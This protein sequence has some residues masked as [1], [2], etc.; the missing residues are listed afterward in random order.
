[1]GTTLSHQEVKDMALTV[2]TTQGNYTFDGPHTSVANLLQQSGV[3]VITTFV[4]GYHK[5]V[6]VGESH[7]IQDR[8]SGHDRNSQW[9]AHIADRLYVSA[10]YCDEQ[11]R[12]LVEG[13][14]RQFHTPPCGVR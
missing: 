2:S 6:D 12:I 5:V 14:V 4:N 1:M 10:L 11:A 7:N 13:A 8:V 3:Y 9:N